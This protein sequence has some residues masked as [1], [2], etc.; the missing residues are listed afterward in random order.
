LDG[1]VVEQNQPD[2]PH[3]HLIELQITWDGKNWQVRVPVSTLETPVV[4]NP[5]C[6][7]AQEEIGMNGYFGATGGNVEEAVNWQQFVSKANLAA[8]CLAVGMPQQSTSDQPHLP[9]AY[10]LYRFGVV[11]AGNDAAYRYWASQ[12]LAD[13]YEQHLIQQLAAQLP[14]Q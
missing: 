12:A 3:E 4:G 5:I 7:S 11:V 8:G 1:H 6:E 13:A 9:M 2:S 10:L 14:S